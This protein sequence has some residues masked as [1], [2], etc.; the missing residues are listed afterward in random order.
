MIF[1]FGPDQTRH[2]RF[3]RVA[4]F[5][6]EER[7]NTFRSAE[8]SAINQLLWRL[9][10]CCCPLWPFR[11]KLEGELS[12]SGSASE[13]L[14]SVHYLSML[15][16]TVVNVDH[17]DRVSN[18]LTKLADELSRR[19]QSVDEEAR[20][21]LEKAERGFASGAFLQWLENPWETIDL[22]KMIAEL[23]M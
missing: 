22:V 10:V 16:R 11:R 12:S 5:I 19:G 2:G 18:D 8:V 13:I 9:W 1:G 6:R 17:L 4:K 23:R 3:L 20:F 15:N 7:Q 21:A 14:K